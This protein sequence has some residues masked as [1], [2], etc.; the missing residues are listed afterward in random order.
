MANTIPAPSDTRSRNLLPVG[1]EVWVRYRGRKAYGY[2]TQHDQGGWTY[3]A[4][5]NPSMNLP[6]WLRSEQ[7][8]IQTETMNII[9]QE[10][11]VQLINGK[12]PQD[13]RRRGWLDANDKL[14]P[15]IRDRM[16]AYTT[17]LNLKKEMGQFK[18][19]THSCRF[20]KLVGG[21]LYTQQYGCWNSFRTY[22]EDGT[23]FAFTMFNGDG[24]ILGVR[25][26]INSTKLMEA[27]N[28]W[29]TN[30][31]FDEF[32]PSDRTDNWIHKL[33]NGPYSQLRQHLVYFDHHH[34]NNW[35]FWWDLEG[36]DRGL[37]YNFLC[38]VRLPWENTVVFN[39]LQFMK[40]Y[41]S[42]SAATFMAHN[43]ILDVQKEQ[44]LPGS[45]TFSACLPISALENAGLEC[46]KRFITN[47]P[48]TN[49]YKTRNIVQGIW[50]D[51]DFVAPPAKAT[52][53]ELKKLAAKYEGG[54]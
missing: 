20:G 44:P 19:M 9:T 52:L 51:G 21:S 54:E 43:Y 29:S 10:Q 38:M 34:H 17:I 30:H 4:W 12:I 32:Y 16:D 28:R 31:N 37:L 1:T 49:S 53:S 39:T 47:E 2:V 36:V 8:N 3:V 23:R 25:D 22:F 6:T 15:L 40:S 13:A 7:L 33:L 42:F 18:K 26:L 45:Y 24:P 50:G 14:V 27:I 11:M 41:M 46:A 5:H 48:R 35:G